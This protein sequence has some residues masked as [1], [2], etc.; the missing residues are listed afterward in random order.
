MDTEFPK[1]FK[2]FFDL[3][4]KTPIQ[5][6]YVLWAQQL[7]WTFSGTNGIESLFHNEPH[8]HGTLQKQMIK[9][10]P[11]TVMNPNEITFKL[12]R[13]CWF[14]EILSHWEHFIGLE[15]CLRM[16]SFSVYRLLSQAWQIWH[17]ARSF[18]MEFPVWILRIWDNTSFLV[19]NVLAQ[20]S[21]ISVLI[22]LSASWIR[23]VCDFCSFSVE[24]LKIWNWKLYWFSYS[25]N[26]VAFHFTFDC[27]NYKGM[28]ALVFSHEFVY[29]HQ[30][31]IWTWIFC[32]IVGMW[33]FWY[34]KPYVATYE[35][36]DRPS[37]QMILNTYRIFSDQN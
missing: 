5:A 26:E 28:L 7:L 12:H 8:E 30:N 13:A 35:H 4:L 27:N 31:D 16:C 25:L 34:Q 22:F 19:A 14:G 36:L 11:K 21:Q 24:N 1:I 29:G 20:Y 6:K 3:M 15:T 23:N 37:L 17:W 18:R 2:Y 10:I 32:R 33:I 9:W